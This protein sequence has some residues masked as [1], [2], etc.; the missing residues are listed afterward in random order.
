MSL[1]RGMPRDHV[2]R[3]VAMYRYR[4]EYFLPPT[5]KAWVGSDRRFD[6]KHRPNDDDHDRVRDRP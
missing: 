4:D 6:N 5:D 3:A 1:F 2:A